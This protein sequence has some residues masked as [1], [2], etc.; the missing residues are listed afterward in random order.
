MKV[1]EAKAETLGEHLLVLFLN[2]L[3]PPV[4]TAPE[5]RKASSM[6]ALH[7]PPAWSGPEAREGCGE[8]WPLLDV[9]GLRS[10]GASGAKVWGCAIGFLFLP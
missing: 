4:A 3:S 2:G 6:H 5:V 10:F 9:W 1:S 7:G 8:A